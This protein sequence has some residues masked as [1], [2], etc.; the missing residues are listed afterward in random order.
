MTNPPHSDKYSQGPGADYGQTPGYP[1]PPGYGAP[2]YGGPGPGAALPGLGLRFAARFVDGLILLVVNIIALFI[3]GFG[4]GWMVVTAIL[5]YA[6][7]VGFDVALGMTPAKKIFNMR[8]VG[9]DGG[10]PQID[11]A[12]KRESFV[13]LGIIPFFGSLLVLAAW[14]AIAVTINSDPQDQGI[15]D[16]FAGG[17]RVLRG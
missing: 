14:I 2:G 12:A 4:I 8:V 15:H 3:L 16:R 5:M 13:L 9:P 11:S 1:P 10:R 6:Y 17:T 7:F